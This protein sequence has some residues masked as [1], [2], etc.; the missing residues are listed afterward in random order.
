LLDSEDLQSD[1]E[2]AQKTLSNTKQ[3][4]NLSIGSAQRLY[5]EA[6]TNQAVS[7]ERIVKD[8]EDAQK[9]LDEAKNAKGWYDDMYENA[10]KNLETATN[11][12]N[13]AVNALGALS[14]V[15]GN[16]VE[17]AKKVV[18]T[19]KAAVEVEQANVSKWLSNYESEKANIQSLEK[20]IETLKQNQVDTQRTTDSSIQSS[21]ES[22]SNAQ[23]Q[24]AGSTRTV[25]K[26]ISTYEEQIDSCTITAPFDGVVTAVNFEKGDVYTGTAVARVEDI[27]SFEVKTEIDEYDIGKI[28]KGQ[29][30]VIKTN[31]TGDEELEGVVKSVAP[32]ATVTL[33]QAGGITSNSVTYTVIVSVLTKND[34]LRLDMTA[35]LSIILDSTNDA[36]TVP[37]DAVMTEEDGTKYVEV[38]DG[39]D[40]KTGLPQTHKEIVTTGLESEYYVVITG[41]NVKEGD[42]IKVTRELSDVF[43]Y[44]IYLND[45]ATTGME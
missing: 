35:K 36:L 39:K 14:S 21:R 43:D 15:S 5:N 32:R 23:I 29:R 11:N 42:E 31:G 16:D 33:N 19:T 22:L 37:Y 13:A 10:K 2:A 41:G 9:K 3:S 26:Q 8:I 12:Y 1:L 30:V 24:A 17:D 28:K 40:E 45:S 44:S 7:A 38:I 27:N 4:N 25:E 20:S 6:V 34:M 18:A